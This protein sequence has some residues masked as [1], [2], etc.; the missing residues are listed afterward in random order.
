MGNIQKKMDKNLQRRQ[1]GAKLL[2]LKGFKRPGSRK[3]KGK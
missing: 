3:K 1:E 2:P